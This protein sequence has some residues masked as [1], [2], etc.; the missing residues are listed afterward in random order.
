MGSSQGLPLAK[1]SRAVPKG[2]GRQERGHSTG[3]DEG[4]GKGEEARVTFLG[5]AGPARQ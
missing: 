3:Q 1:G 2:T 5:A 4:G